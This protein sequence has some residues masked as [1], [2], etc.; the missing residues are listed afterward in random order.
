MLR[1]ALLACLGWNGAV[2]G[3]AAFVPS[4]LSR[5][6]DQ[7]ASDPHSSVENVNVTEL[8]R[9]LMVKESSISNLRAK[10]VQV[11]LGRGRKVRSCI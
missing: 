6:H 3:E 5:T 11:R 4:L 8:Q 9:D 7:A 10:I 1:V 2:A